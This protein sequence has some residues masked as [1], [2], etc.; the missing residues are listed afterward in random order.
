MDEASASS[1]PGQPSPQGVLVLGY[2]RHR[3][4][5]GGI[6]LLLAH[7]GAPFL[8][9]RYEVGDGPDW[10]KS[11]WYDEAETLGLGA[12]PNLPY[13]IDGD[14]RVVQ[15]DAILRYLARKFG[16]EGDDDA[17][18]TLADQMV[19]VA[20]DQMDTFLSLTYAR[21]LAKLRK[22]SWDEAA[23]EGERARYVE[24]RAPAAFAKF[25]AHLRGSRAT[26][27]ATP[28]FPWFAGA[29]VTYADFFIYELVDQ[30]RGFCGPGVLDG[31]PLLTSFMARLEALENVSR[32]L[33]SDAF[34]ARPYHNRYSQFTVAPGEAPYRAVHPGAASVARWPPE[35]PTP[36]GRRRLTDVN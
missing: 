32:Y 4:L 7:C 17:E 12:F 9:R 10:D 27:P 13:L 2:W 24:K 36:S 34:L 25:E 8:D 5:A 23:W 31:L 35:G 20:K 21:W 19:G 16:L 15:S 3:V 14:V 28:S 6:R 26:T 33:A 1:V 22:Q 30:H 11:C 18:K 29:R